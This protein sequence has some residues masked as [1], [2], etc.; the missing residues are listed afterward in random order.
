VQLYLCKNAD[1]FRIHA[2]RV[3]LYFGGVG[4]EIRKL[5]FL[6]KKLCQTLLF[7]HTYADL[8]R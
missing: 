3:K 1:M 7:V 8:V 5:L 6:I 4:R 2:I